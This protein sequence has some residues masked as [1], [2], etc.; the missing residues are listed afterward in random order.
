[1]IQTINDLNTSYPEWTFL[2]SDLVIKEAKNEI[3][4]LNFAYNETHEN[5]DLAKTVLYL[6]LTKFF[7]F[8]Y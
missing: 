8:S 5:E 4:Q 7:S 2:Y 3:P 6:R 1:M